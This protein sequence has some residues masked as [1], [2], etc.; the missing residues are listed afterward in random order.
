MIGDY[1]DADRIKAALQWLKD[2]K[3]ATIRYS[4]GSDL[5]PFV[6]LDVVF[7]DLRPDERPRIPVFP[8]AEVAAF[9]LVEAVERAKARYWEIASEQQRTKG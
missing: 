9:D 2:Q 7:F 1:E 6:S 4:I 8:R 3:N 5:R